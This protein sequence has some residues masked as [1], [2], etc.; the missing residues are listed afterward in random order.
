MN[1][2]LGPAKALVEEICDDHEGTKKTMKEFSQKNPLVAPFRLAWDIITDDEDDAKETL[3]VFIDNLENMAN[4]TPLL[5]HT[6]ALGHAAAGNDEKAKEVYLQATRT[7]IVAGAGLIGS[8]AGPVGTV[9]LAAEVGTGW[10]MCEALAG[11]RVH[12]I[13]KLITAA[14]DH[15]ELGPGEVFDIVMTPVGDGMTGL[16]AKQLCDKI[17]EARAKNQA[18]NQVQKASEV[19]LNLE[20]SKANDAKLEPLEKKIAEQGVDNPRELAERMSKD[21]DVLKN[22]VEN[23]ES[24]LRGNQLG[25]NRNNYHMNRH[26]TCTMIDEEGN[27]S[28][29]YSSRITAA[30]GEKRFNG[31]ISKLEQNYPEYQSVID[32]RVLG[33]CAEPMAYEN[34]SNPSI[35]YAMQINDGIV[36]AITR[37]K[38][39][40]QYNFGTVITDW[41]DGE[42]IPLNLDDLPPSGSY[43]GAGINGTVLVTIQSRKRRGKGD[44]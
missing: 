24:A 41:I 39:C 1:T 37:C 23:H 3:Q 25:R 40:A 6:I 34:C 9:A 14:R 33:N 36:K 44:A 10:D 18:R 19:V 13:P 11:G 27:S 30:T 16:L 5:G 42:I 17:T 38:N 28:T 20:V 35:T 26:V 22:T 15:I 7:T 8:L 43:I 31:D 12:G 21:A 2:F 29:G 4:S 32:G